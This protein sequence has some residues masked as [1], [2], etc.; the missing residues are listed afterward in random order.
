MRRNVQRA[1]LTLAYRTPGL[2][3]LLAFLTARRVTVKG[4]SMYPTLRASERVLFD[5]LAYRAGRPRRDDIVLARHP[6]RPGVRFIKRVAAVP[7]DDVH[8]NMV[9]GRETAAVPLGPDEYYLLGDNPAASTDSRHLGP[10]RRRD[11]IAR[12]WLVYWPAERFRTLK[13]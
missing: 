12:A 2:Y 6:Q 9:D 4:Y 8:A 7:G 1:L 10:F 11:I 3:P 13:R 5:T